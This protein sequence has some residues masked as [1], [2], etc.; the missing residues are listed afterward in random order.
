MTL[1]MLRNGPAAQQWCAQHEANLAL[2]QDIRSAITLPRLGSGIGNERHA[3]RGS[4]EV[5]RLAGVAY[6]ELHVVRSQQRKE[7]RLGGGRLKDSRSDGC[8]RNGTRKCVHYR[9]SLAGSEGE[10]RGILT[11]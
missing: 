5:G 1:D 2:L 3:K 6:I 8:R 7:I 10:T 4:I 9:T 11:D